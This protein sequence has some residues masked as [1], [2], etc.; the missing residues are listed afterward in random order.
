MTDRPDS[1]NPCVFSPVS[2]FPLPPLPTPTPPH[3]TPVYPPNLADLNEF[4]LVLLYTRMTTLVAHTAYSLARLEAKSRAVSDEADRETTLRFV[5][6]ESSSTTE[7]KERAKA[8][9]KVMALNSEKSLYEQ[10]AIVI[11]ALLDGYRTMLFSI[12]HEMERRR[13]EH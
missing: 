7:R 12:K 10:D 9:R 6:A 8:S 4:E 11:R 5:H 2:S 1:E 13:Y 3:E